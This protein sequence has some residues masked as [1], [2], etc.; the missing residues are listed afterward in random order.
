MLLD[1][2]T[3]SIDVGVDVA[4]VAF[5][6]C[7]P[8]RVEQVLPGIYVAGRRGKQ[9]EYVE[10]YWRQVDLFTG[11]LYLMLGKVYLEFS[12]IENFWLRPTGVGLGSLL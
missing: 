8:D 2:G 7:I 1:F 3:K 5:I 4:F 11:D 9:P 12:K 6:G 10:F